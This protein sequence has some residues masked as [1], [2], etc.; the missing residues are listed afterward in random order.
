M[1][2]GIKFTFAPITLL[3]LMASQRQLSNHLNKKAASYS[4]NLRRSCNIT[5]LEVLKLLSSYSV[6]LWSAWF[7]HPYSIT[8]FN[9][10]T[11][12]INSTSTCTWQLENQAAVPDFVEGF[13]YVE[14]NG[15]R[16]FASL[17]IVL[18]WA[19]VLYSTTR[20]TW[21]MAE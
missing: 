11:T 2:Q 5:R 15:G 10:T 16:I 18:Y 6:V 21:W 17:V 4:F 9:W 7:Y 19:I 20:W 14:K 3:I 13:R 1:Q 12:F 8:F